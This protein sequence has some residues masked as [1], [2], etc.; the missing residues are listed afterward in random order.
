MYTPE[1]FKE[2]RIDVLSSAIADIQFA[3]L[4]SATSDG[5]EVTHVPMVLKTEGK[6]L[7]LESHI[8][9]AN[10]HW[11]KL[12]E[13]QAS[14]AIFQGSQAYITPSWYPTKEKTGKV[15]PTW[16]YIAVH[17]RGTLQVVQDED[18]LMHH[19]D[20]LTQQ[21]EADRADKWNVAD[22][23]EKFIRSLGRG[24]VG[25]RMEIDT[26]EGKWKINQNKSEEDRAGTAKGLSTAGEMGAKLASHIAE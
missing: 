13:S 12:E 24:I 19:L 7:V 15:V 14:V 1:A 22:A 26:L 17:A 20:E 6:K 9:R 23:P 10:S 4:V 21:N 5:M 2:D 25:L 16:A 11:S 8:A 18:W 3:A